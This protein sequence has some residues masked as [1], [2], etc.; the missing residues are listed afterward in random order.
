MSFWYVPRGVLP[1]GR[2]SVK[3]RFGPGLNLLMRLRM[4][5]AAQ[6]ATSE[7]EFC[8]INF[9]AWMKSGVS[10]MKSGEN[11]GKMVWSSD[12]VLTSKISVG[13]A[14]A[15]YYLLSPVDKTKSLSTQSQRNTL[16]SRSEWVE[17]G[18]ED[19]AQTQSGQ[20]QI[21]VEKRKLII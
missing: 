17:R 1:V 10:E 7:D 14:N 8:R 2:P 20:Q 12:A 13:K 18:D 5:L 3:N 19:R 15:F 6:T 9:I 16:I 11:V 4:Y 21:S